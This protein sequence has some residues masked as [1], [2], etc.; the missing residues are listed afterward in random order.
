M[1]KTEICKEKIGETIMSSRLNTFKITGLFI[2][3]G[4]CTLSIAQKQDSMPKINTAEFRGYFMVGGNI[5]DIDALNS[6]LEN[7]GY[8][9]LSNNFLSIG[10]GCLHQKNRWII[11]CEGHFLF[12]EENKSDITSGNFETSISAAY[13]FFDFGYILFNKH[14]FQVYPLIGLGGG[15]MSLKIKERLTDPSFAEVLADPK[16]NSKLESA[17]FLINMAIGTEY[18]MKLREDETGI[19]GLV[20]GIRVGYTFA[21]FRSNWKLERTDVSN[22]PDLRMTGP[23]VRLILGGWGSKNN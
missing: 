17:A 18:L 2:L 9:T 16:R 21:P 7:E 6:I 5:L 14:F 20:L 19:G 12:G 23:Y 4:F 1:I 13:G 10:G 8:S 3:L 11:G 22:G 15:V